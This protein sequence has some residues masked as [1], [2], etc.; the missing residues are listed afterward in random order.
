[1]ATAL[2]VAKPVR[3]RGFSLRRLLAYASRETLEIR[4]DPIRLAFALLGPM[5]LMIVLGFGISFD[6]EHLSYGVLDRDQTP[7]S[8]SY[9]ENFAGSRYFRERPLI[10]D[11]EELERRMASGELR[12]AV[13]IPPGFA[14]DLKRERSPEVNVW[15][16]GAMPSRGETMR[17]YV[18]G[19]HQL[20]LRNL[21][22]GSPVTAAPAGIQF[23]SIATTR[24]S[25]AF[26]Q[27]CRV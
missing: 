3:A 2:H 26:T 17:G 9:L 20:Y 12:V 8:R 11:Y 21:Q 10:R 5:L 13:E 15:I 16:D 18:Q 1:V 6:V 23:R 25:R 24:I 22:R 27:S 7:E 14:K 19:L 4:R